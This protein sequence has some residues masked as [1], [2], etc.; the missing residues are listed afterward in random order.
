MHVLKELDVGQLRKDLEELREDGINS[1]A[2][3]LMHSYLYPNHEQE[4]ALVAKE[5]GFKQV[6]LSSDVMSMVRIVP[7]GF[8]GMMVVV[9][10]TDVLTYSLYKALRG[11]RHFPTCLARVIGVDQERHA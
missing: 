10:T 5:M 6:S 11:S 2:V 7:R 3:V 8:T 9:V 1:L 4:V